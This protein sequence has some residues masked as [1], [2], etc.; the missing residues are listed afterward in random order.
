MALSNPDSVGPR[1]HPVNGG[2]SPV[3]SPTS[4]SIILNHSLHLAKT[5]PFSHVRNQRLH[6]GFVNF[7][8]TWNGRLAMMGF[9]IGLGT[10]LLTGQGILSQLGL[11]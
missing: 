2:K 6:F 7:A 4:L 8:E 5:T 10:E 11:G 3:L 9:V 1:G